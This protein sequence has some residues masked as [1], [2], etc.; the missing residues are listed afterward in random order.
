M[1]R[2]LEGEGGKTIADGMA[3]KGLIPL[4]G[5][6]LVRVHSTTGQKRRSTRLRMLR[7]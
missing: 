6:M 7:A 3:A 1:F 2:V 5:M 4:H